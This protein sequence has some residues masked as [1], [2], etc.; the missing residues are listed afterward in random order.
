MNRWNGDEAKALDFVSQLYK[1]VPVLD[2][3]ARGST[4]TFAQ[5]GLGDVLLAWENEAYL[6]LAEFG[7]LAL[8]LG[9]GQL[10]E[11]GLQA[12]DARHRLAVGFEQAVVAAAEDFGQE[13][14]GHTNIAPRPCWTAGEGW[15]KFGSAWKRTRLRSIVCDL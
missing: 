11:L 6:A 13:L 10:L 9:V 3:G 7:G 12:V 2:S 1:N 15:L 8:Q 5:R 14:D 4:I